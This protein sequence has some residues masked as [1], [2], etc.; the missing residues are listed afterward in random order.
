MQG[1]AWVGFDGHKTQDA[2]G[3][4]C[5]ICVL[6]DFDLVGVLGSSSWEPVRA[7]P[8]VKGQ[9]GQEFSDSF[10]GQRESCTEQ[11]D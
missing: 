3:L 2:S 5:V 10:W 9:A 6:P 1:A 4:Q 11:V 8:A 7:Q